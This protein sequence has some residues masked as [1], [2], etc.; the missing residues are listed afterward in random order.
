MTEDFLSSCTSGGCGAKI[1]ASDLSSYLRALPHSQD[2]S[3]LVGFSSGDDAAVYQTAEDQAVVS[4]LDFFS[5][6]VEDPYVF[7][8]IAAA[9]ALS[10]VYAMGGKAIMALNVTC[11][12]ERLPK[13]MLGQILAGGAAKVQE[14]GAALAGGHSIYDHEPKYGLAV[15]GLVDPRKLI[16]NDTPETGDTLILTKALGVG[17]ILAADRAKVGDA[18]ATQ[19]AIA[20]MQR[21]NKYATDKFPAYQIHACTDITGFGLLAHGLEMAGTD[22]TLVLDTEELPILPKALDFANDYLV[23]AGGQ[24][25][26]EQIGDKVAL[27]NV[28][29]GLQEILFDP[30][31]SGG[32]LISVATEDAADLLAA[33]QVDDPVARIV[34]LVTDR[35]E[36]PITLL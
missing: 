30:Q 16:H 8:T 22:H 10:D 1:A 36:N 25:N 7:G 34:G 18:A 31:T 19:A 33:I 14:A 21:L 17:I 29:F 5:P 24:R 32:L 35:E 28:P 27:S 3:L 26:R 11:F 13:E 9:N 2:P 4:T 20:S 6:M 23:T 15:T 12:P